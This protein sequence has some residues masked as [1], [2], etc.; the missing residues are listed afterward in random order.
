[1]EPIKESNDSVPWC[2][3]IRICVAERVVQRVAVRISTLRQQQVSTGVFG[4]G[5]REPSLRARHIP[6]PE[7]IEARLGI[8]FLAGKAV[9]ISRTAPA[10]ESAAEDRIMK[11]PRP[12]IASLRLDQS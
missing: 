7:V 1:M 11:S 10:K 12:S 4:I 3:A 9:R 6:S 8:P 5:R 2:L